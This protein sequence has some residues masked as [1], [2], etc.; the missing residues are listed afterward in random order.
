MM[1]PCQTKE[2]FPI[3]RA[4]EAPKKKRGTLSNKESSPISRNPKE[5]PKSP[6]PVA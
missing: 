1:K 2:N 4:K 5:Q 3:G 6:K